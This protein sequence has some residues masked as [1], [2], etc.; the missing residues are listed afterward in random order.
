MVFKSQPDAP[1]VVKLHS[2]GAIQQTRSNTRP[3][4]GNVMHDVDH[5]VPAEHDQSIQRDVALTGT[6]SSCCG[7]T[8]LGQP[9]VSS[10]QRQEQ[11]H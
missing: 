6:G 5:P 3:P 9:G 8:P 4:E 10:G 1:C 11:V 2:C 7:A